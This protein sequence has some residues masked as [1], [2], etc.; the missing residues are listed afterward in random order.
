MKTPIQQLI[1]R[2]ELLYDLNPTELDYREGLAAA[3]TE[4]KLML[5]FEKMHIKHAWTDGGESILTQTATAY[6][7]NTYQ[8]Q[9][10]L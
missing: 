5:P 10:Q 4:A 1:D 8:Q 3:V 9:N 2:L 7:N 6:F